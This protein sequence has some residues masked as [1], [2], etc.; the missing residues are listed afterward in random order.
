MMAKSN[1]KVPFDP[2]VFLATVNGGRTLSKYKKGETLF[3]QGA[4]HPRGSTGDRRC[5]AG[6][7]YLAAGEMASWINPRERR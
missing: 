7:A 5:C 1:K 2:K 3:S 6:G 4:P